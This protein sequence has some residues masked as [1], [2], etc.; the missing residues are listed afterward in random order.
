MSKLLLAALEEV[1][2][3]SEATWEDSQA[4]RG[5]AADLREYSARLMER[6]AALRKRLAPFTPPSP[7]EVRQAESEMLAMFRDKKPRA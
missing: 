3:V 7:E 1:R 6:G 2:V 4:V 5:K